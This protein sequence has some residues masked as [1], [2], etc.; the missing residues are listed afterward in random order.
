MGLTG[1]LKKGGGFLNNVDALVDDANFV[2][3]ETAKIKKGKNK[4]K[5]F[6]PL[7]LVVEFKPDGADETT[8]QRLLIGNADNLTYEISDDGKTIT[9]EDGGGIF[10]NSE[11]GTF[12]A[13]CVAPEE[14]DLS[15]PDDQFGEADNEYTIAVLVGSRVRLVRPVNAERPK[16]VDKNG[17]EWDARDLKVFQVYEL[18]GGK[19]AK[20]GAKPAAGKGK[21]AKVEEADEVDPNEAAVQ[22]LLRYLE[23]A[24][25]QTLQVSKLKMKATTDPTFRTDKALRDAVIELLEDADFL[26]DVDD[27]EY[28][29]KKGTVSIPA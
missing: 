5:D 20:S 1:K 13:S 24:K 21:P 25:D 17:K 10:A 29:G 15:F 28:N 16:Q 12:L 2:T 18:G 6:T 9:F 3:G 11:A 26:K 7:S 19:K 22:A 23:S 8:P 14:G 4:G 27:V